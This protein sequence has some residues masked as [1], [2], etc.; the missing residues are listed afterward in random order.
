VFGIG[1]LGT[2]GVHAC[3][4]VDVDDEVVAVDVLAVVV[5]AVDVVSV[6]VVAVD[7]VA[8]EVLSVDVVA[9]DVV[10]VDVGAVD[11][12]PVDVVT[13]DVLAVGVVAV[14]V[15]AVVSVVVVG[16]S[17]LEVVVVGGAVAVVAVVLVVGPPMVLVVDVLVVAVVT[18]VD[19][20]VWVVVVAPE[21]GQ[22]SESRST[23]MSRRISSAF[24]RS[25]TS[26][27]HRF[28]S[29]P[30]RCRY[31][32]NRRMAFCRRDFAR[33]VSPLVQCASA[34]SFR[35]FARSTSERR[36]AG[37]APAVTS[38]PVW[39]ISSS[40]RQSREAKSAPGRQLS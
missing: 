38:A 18:V 10:A 22:T 3:I 11:V 30:R 32:I 40:S 25:S 35:S 19:G 27:R 14:V 37:S 13:V 5:G 2:M 31:P 29:V 39:A 9:V 34:C 17:V 36:T 28:P 20:C 6:E 12:L 21:G 1:V 15:V 26:P 24:A 8:V 23:C 33:R 4:V 7:V 16:G